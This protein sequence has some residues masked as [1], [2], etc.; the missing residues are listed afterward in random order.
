MYQSTGKIVFNPIP[1]DGSKP[2][3]SWWAIVECPHDIIEYYRYWVTKNQKFKL[4]F[5]SFGAHISIIRDEEP[6]DDFKYLWKKRDG[7]LVNFTYS[8]DFETNGEY[9]WLNVHCPVLNEI[10]TELGLP[11]E[12]EYGYHLS[13]GKIITK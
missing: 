6:P 9:Y 7:M 11:S 13:I 1:R 12:P 4:N 2:N 10:R 3:K 8:P 5:P